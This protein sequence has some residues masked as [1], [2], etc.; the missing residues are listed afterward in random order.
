MRKSL[1]QQR[2]RPCQPCLHGA[3]GQPH[4]TRSRA[5]VHFLKVKQNHGFAV[6]HGKCQ[7]GSPQGLL[8]SSFLEFAVLGSG[9]RRFVGCLFRQILNREP[10]EFRP[11]HIGSQRKEP[12]GEAALTPP[13]HQALPSS[14]EGLLRQFFGAPAIARVAPSHVDEGPLPPPHNSLKRGN[15]SGEHALNVG[16]VVVRA[17]GCRTQIRPSSRCGTWDQPNRLHFVVARALNEEFATSCR[18]STRCKASSPFV[19]PFG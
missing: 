16:Q 3:F 1:S 8:P 5:Y 17:V 6:A 18:H 7:Y 11:K 14:D 4:G 12:S 19:H 13:L 10:F 2:P 15:F 9:P